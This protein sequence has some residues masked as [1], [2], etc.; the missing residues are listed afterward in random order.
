MA[1]LTVTHTTVYRYKRPV[2]FG[3]HRLM[4]RPRDSHDL[5]LVDSSLTISPPAEVRWLHDVFSNS[6][7]IAS[8]HDAAEELRFESRIMLD[9]FGL[10]NPE[11]NIEPYAQTYPFSYPAEEIPDLGRSVE[12]DYPD[13][14]RKVDAWVKGFLSEG[15]PIGTQDLLVRIT[16]AIHEQFSY[17]KRYSLGTQTPVE[18]LEAG[19]GTCRDLAAFMMGAVRALGLAARFVSGYLYDPA[20]DNTL[21][22]GAAQDG[23]EIRGA[24]DTHAWVQVY[25]PGA[26]WVEFDPTNGLVGGA[27]LIRVAV[28]REPYQA[29]PLQGSYYGGADDFLEMNV[30]VRVTRG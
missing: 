24:G 1:L 30:E 10:E 9:H 17:A 27:N 15:G 8:F 26:G 14:E 22:G 21:P 28:A 12:R 13:P 2:R 6:I 20:L 4:F 18:T 19:S 3:E 16:K 29:L 25:L 5:R 7:A 23:D 11:F